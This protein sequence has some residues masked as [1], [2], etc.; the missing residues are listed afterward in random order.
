MNYSILFGVRLPQ[1]VTQNPAGCIPKS[2]E[3][4]PPVVLPPYQCII[5]ARHPRCYF[6]DA[7]WMIAASK[8]Y[9]MKIQQAVTGRPMWQV[10]FMASS[11]RVQKRLKRGWVYVFRAERPV[12]TASALTGRI[13]VAA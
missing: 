7:K 4:H 9:V 5:E 13:D 6:D 11:Q 8:E 12:L 3:S 1:F 10:S 2:G